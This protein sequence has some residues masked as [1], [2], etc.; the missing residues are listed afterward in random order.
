[1][2]NECKYILFADDTTLVFSNEN[3]IQLELSMNGR[4]VTIKK[5][6]SYK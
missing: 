4:T 2:S 5:L 1:M 6:V 3:S